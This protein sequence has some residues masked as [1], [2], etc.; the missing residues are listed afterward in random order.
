MPA[1]CVVAGCS[2]TRNLKL[3]IGLH[4]IPY[5]GDNRPEA[6]KRRKKWVDFVKTK[7]A[8]WEPSESSVI[9]SKHFVPEDFTRRLDVTIEGQG[10][11]LTPWLQRDDF[12][13]SAIPSVHASAME[14]HNKPLSDRERRM[15]RLFPFFL[16]FISQQL[17]C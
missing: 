13:I 16:E 8:K 10:T 2:N 7:R 1:R 12:G 9:F 14:A 3:G 6:R 17:P 15:V 5:Y 4:T 11:P